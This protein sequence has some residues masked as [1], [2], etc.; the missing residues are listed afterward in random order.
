MLERGS[1]LHLTGR[2]KIKSG[3]KFTLNIMER[4]ISSWASRICPKQR[5]L[6]SW[7]HFHFQGRQVIVGPLDQEQKSG[8]LNCLGWNSLSPR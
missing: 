6:C 4:E 2:E 3:S 1:L 8:F 5:S 7:H